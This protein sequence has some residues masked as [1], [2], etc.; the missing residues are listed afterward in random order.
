MVNDEEEEYAN[1]VRVWNRWGWMDSWYGVGSTK[2]MMQNG[3][4]GQQPN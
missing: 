4:F 1:S 2:G 3:V